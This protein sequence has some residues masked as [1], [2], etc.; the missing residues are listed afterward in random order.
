M[1]TESFYQIQSRDLAVLSMPQIRK[2][3]QSLVGQSMVQDVSD[4]LRMKIFDFE[5]RKPDFPSK[6]V[7]C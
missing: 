2:T 6:I 7:D 3:G 4:K 5:N 1:K